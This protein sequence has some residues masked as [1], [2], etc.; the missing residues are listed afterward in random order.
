MAVL[1][2]IILIIFFL[3]LVGIVIWV[4]KR[5]KDDTSD[6]FLSGC[7]FPESVMGIDFWYG[8]SDLYC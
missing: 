4:V 7:I 1:D 5:G 3:C 6:C 2:W 8:T